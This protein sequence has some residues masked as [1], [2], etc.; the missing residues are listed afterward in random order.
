MAICHDVKKVTSIDTGEQSF[1][2]SSMD[3]VVINDMLN[4]IEFISFH[5]LNN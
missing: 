5:S 3:E 4:Q 1:Q 2:G